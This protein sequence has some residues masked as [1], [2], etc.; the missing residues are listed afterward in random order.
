TMKK[1]LTLA[2]LLAGVLLISLSIR[3]G[4][5][6][7]SPGEGS[8][9]AVAQAGEL[10]ATAPAAQ[11][12]TAPADAA[13]EAAARQLTIADTDRGRGALR[14]RVVTA[15]GS[16]AI[17]HSAVQAV[18]RDGR[19]DDASRIVAVTDQSGCVLFADLAAGPW[20]VSCDRAAVDD[21]GQRVEVAPGRTADV[22]LRSMRGIDAIVRVQDREGTGVPGAEVIL[23]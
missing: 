14:V 22:T 16:A 5:D 11:D 8:G 21:E 6:A 17:P 2:A 18:A 12:G 9:A 13:A 7:P 1:S 3:G 20:L 4:G 15:D 10:L 23:W 19:P